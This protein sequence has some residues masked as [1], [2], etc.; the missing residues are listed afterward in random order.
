MMRYVRDCFK[1]EGSHGLQQ[2]YL[3]TQSWQDRFS[4]ELGH[5]VPPPEG[6]DVMVK[7]RDCCLFAPQLPQADQV[8]L[9]SFLAGVDEDDEPPELALDPGKNLENRS[10]RVAQLNR[11]VASIL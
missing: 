3:P 11:P 8:P 10:L 6:L 9:Q 2:E 5:G 1:V 7:E 4:G